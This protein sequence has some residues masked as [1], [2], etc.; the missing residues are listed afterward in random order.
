MNKLPHLRFEVIWIPGHTE[1]EA[2][3][4][5]DAEA[6][7][8][9]LDPTLSQSHNYKLLKSARIR[10]IKTA[11]KKQWQTIWNTNTKTAKALR[12]IM[13]G[14]HAKIG[15]ALYNEIA[16]R[17]G[18]AIIAQL[19]TAHC[20]LNRYLHRF[21]L[22][23]SP[24]CQCGYGKETVEHYLLECRNHRDQRKKLRREVG[25]GKMRMEILLGDRRSLNRRW[26]ISRKQR[27]W[28]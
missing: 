27:D 12:R 13:K 11:A 7:K 6:K 22:R 2:N 25:R 5:D 19:R 28:I 4:L 26:S 16:S 17:H 14:R 9:V 23:N 1:I 21:S 24:Y 18:S 10:H 8:A 3:E 20:G 15:P